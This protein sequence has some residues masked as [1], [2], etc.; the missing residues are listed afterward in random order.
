MGLLDPHGDLVNAILAKMTKR[1]DDVI[2]LDIQDEDHPFGLNIF[3]CPNPQSPTAVQK[4]VDLVMHIFE[5]LYDV[6]RA[7]S[8][9][10]TVFTKLYLYAGC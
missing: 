2:L 9:Y 3:E 1:E 10:G 6:S 7:D 8:P 5:K 4:I